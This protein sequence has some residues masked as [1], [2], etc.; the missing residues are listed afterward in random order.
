MYLFITLEHPAVPG[1]EE[2][3]HTGTTS[4]FNW[5]FSMWHFSFPQ[6]QGDHQVDPFWRHGGHQDGH[7]DAAEGHPR[8]TIPVVHRSVAEKDGKVHET[9]W[10]GNYVVCCLEL[11]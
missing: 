9:L 7:N 6:A 11:K 3:R 8:G 1:W 4:L 2:H 5:S 10:R